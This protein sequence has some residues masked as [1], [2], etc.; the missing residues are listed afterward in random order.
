M[1]WFNW[2]DQKWKWVWWSEEKRGGFFFF[3][4]SQFE[5][6]LM[7]AWKLIY[8]RFTDKSLHFQ[9]PPC[10][11]QRAL[12]YFNELRILARRPKF[13]SSIGNE[14]DVF[15]FVLLI[16]DHL[17]WIHSTGFHPTPP[18]MFVLHVLFGKFAKSSLSF[19]WHFFTE[20]GDK[21][22]QNV[23]KSE[24]RKM[25]SLKSQHFEKKNT[26]KIRMQEKL[27]CQNFL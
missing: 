14:K 3:C 26:L 10:F 21:K 11:S 5:S 20:V 7:L 8:V 25:C 12:P 6:R 4:S 1:R 19:F 17:S 27:R 24:F 15:N 18:A 9:S 2:I 23:I 16:A 22:N 13:D